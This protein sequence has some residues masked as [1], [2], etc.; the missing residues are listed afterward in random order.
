MKTIALD[1]GEGSVMRY[2]TNTQRTILIRGNTDVEIT[3]TKCW[4]F[5]L[6]SK[7]RKTESDFVYKNFIVESTS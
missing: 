1:G 5:H 6:C 7:C 3:T 4:W 2:T